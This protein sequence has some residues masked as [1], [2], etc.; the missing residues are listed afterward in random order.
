[1]LDNTFSREEST[2]MRYL[3]FAIL[4]FLLILLATASVITTETKDHDAVMPVSR[5]GDWMKRHQSMNARVAKGN[6]DLVLIG[7]SLTHGWERGGKT[8]WQKFYGDRNAVNLGIGSDRTQHVIWRLQN[9]NLEGIAPKLAV[10]MIGTNNSDS[11]TAEQIADGVGAVVAVVKEKTP[12]T[13]I[14]VLAIFPR[15]A[16]DQDDR[17]QLN[18]KAN[19]LIAK[20]ADEESVFFLNINDKFLTEDRVLTPEIMP[21]LRHL[22]YRGY[23]IWALSMEPMV[24]RLMG[25]KFTD[26][27]G[28][29][30]RHSRAPSHPR[31]GK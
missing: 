27:S 12:T 17:R 3:P 2:F 25:E 20:L 23:V 18:M 24:A 7:D 4:S 14:L 11:N 10:I 9:G 19:E 22:R 26:R 31:S 13:K 16:T 21:D 8:I 1:M 29:F 5:D 6:V 30:P 15:G 28:Q